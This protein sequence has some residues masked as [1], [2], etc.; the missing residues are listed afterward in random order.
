MLRRPGT[1]GSTALARPTL[2]VITTLALA[3]SPGCTR[4]GLGLDEAADL[5]SQSLAASE[6]EHLQ[7]ATPSGCFLLARRDEIK[8]TDVERD[9][10]IARL[11]YVLS[12][13]RRERDLGLIE[14][15]FSE[16]PADA[17]VPPMGCG[18]LWAAQHA[19]AA[20]VAAASR[21][22]FV[23]WKAT[24][25]DKAMAAGLQPGETFLYLRKTLIDVVR[26]SKKD[27]E[28]MIAE[29]R[30]RWAPSYEGEHLGIQPSGP[31]AGKARFKNSGGGWRLAR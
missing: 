16:T 10:Q 31:M 20:P 9:P 5:L 26:L 1:C 21:F 13:L 18:Q 25:S 3:L 29:Y 7:L 15:E 23:V 14:F 2:A 22:K 24:P 17:P 11:P 6:S 19:G 8:N 28:T 4:S 30:W 12:T 27:S